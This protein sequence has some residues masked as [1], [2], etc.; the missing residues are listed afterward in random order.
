MSSFFS[1]PKI[2]AHC[3]ILE[4]DRFPYGEKIAYHPRGQ[5]MGDV[6]YFK[7]LMACYNVEHALLVGP[8]SGYGTDNRCL[9]DA[10]TQSRPNQFKGIAVVDNDCP[11]EELQHLKSVGVIGVA[12]NPSLM[13]NDFYA[14]IEPLLQRLKQLDMWA[15]FQV[16]HNLLLDFVPMI[17]RSQVKFMVDHC[18]RPLLQAGIEQPGFQALLALGRESRQAGDS[19]AVVKLSGFAKFSKA[20]YPFEDVR[21]YLHAL[22]DSFGLEQCVW[23]SDWPYLKAPY[24]LDYGPMLKIYETEFTEKERAILMYESARRLFNF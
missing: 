13:G 17:E 2:D 22:T 19:R 1:E 20:G 24:R 4:P 11:L 8:N 21:P 5:E 15:Q 9:I 23:A 12:F 6:K 3:H 14:N 7:Q 10:L 16:E 18:G